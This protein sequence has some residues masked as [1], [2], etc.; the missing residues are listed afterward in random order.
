MG[1]LGDVN[2]P[3]YVESVRLEN[4]GFEAAHELCPAAIL[5]EIIAILSMELT[6]MLEMRNA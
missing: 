4:V 3:F 2:D 1:F 5:V 6:H